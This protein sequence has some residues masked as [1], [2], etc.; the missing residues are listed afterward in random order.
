[1]MGTAVQASADPEVFA[2]VSADAEA[3]KVYDLLED[4]GFDFVNIRE[5]TVDV[6]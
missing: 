1:M 2:F 6:V 3:R 4:P 5:M